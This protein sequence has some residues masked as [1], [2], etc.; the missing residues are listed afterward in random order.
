MYIALFAIS[1][2]CSQI[3]FRLQFNSLA[4]LIRPQL[5]STCLNGTCYELS[6]QV[7]AL[8]SISFWLNNKYELTKALN[9]SDVKNAKPRLLPS[10][11]KI[12]HYTF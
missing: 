12:H 9:R 1:E 6:I 2:Q 10:Y 5:A 11:Q 4:G 7:L 8:N 3:L